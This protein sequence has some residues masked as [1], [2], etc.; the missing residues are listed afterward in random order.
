MKLTIMDYSDEKREFDIGDKEDIALITS[1]V[2]S[3]DEVAEILY[4][5]F[6]KRTFDSSDDRMMNYYDF[7][8]E[9][10]NCQKEEN[11]INDPSWQNRKT[12]YDVQDC[13][14]DYEHYRAEQTEPQTEREGE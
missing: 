5:D 11:L 7:E 4:K 13:P 3:G 9:L 12:S 8:Y 10:Y 1:S 2:I 6:T 14:N